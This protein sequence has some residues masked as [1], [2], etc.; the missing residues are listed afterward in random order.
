MGSDGIRFD[1]LHEAAMTH[2]N[3][4]CNDFEDCWRRGEP[5][6]IEDVMQEVEEALRPTLIRELLPIEIMYH[7]RSGISV[8][9]D[10][11][12]EQF[13]GFSETWFATIFQETD[14]RDAFEPD[15]IDPTK[16]AEFPSQLGDYTIV[17]QIGVGGMG[18]VYEAHHERMARAVAIKVLRSELAFQPQT[19]A[20]FLREIR[21]AASLSHPNIVT[22]YDSRE[23]NGM[24]YLVTELVDGTN[25]GSLV[26]QRGP[27]PHSEAIEYVVQAANGLQ[28]AH[29]HGVIHRDI[30]PQNLMLTMDQSISTPEPRPR[31]K[32]LD[33]G[34]AQL[35]C[36][37]DSELTSA[38]TIM[39]TP[40]YMAPEQ[41][42]RP[43]EVDHRADIYSLGC[44]LYYL[45]TA[46][47]AYAGD[48]VIETTMA[49]VNQPIPELVDV[50]P[51][52]AAIMKPVLEKMM[53]KDPAARFQSMTDVIA[54]LSQIEGVGQITVGTSSRPRKNLPALAGTRRRSLRPVLSLGVVVPLLCIGFA[55]WMFFR[56]HPIDVPQ[57]AALN[58]SVE[59]AATALG[60][61]W[62]LSFDGTTSFI[63]ADSP[64][65]TGEPVTIEAIVTVRDPHISVVAVWFDG[66][67]RAGLGVTLEGRWAIGR[68]RSEP[69]R[70]H[71]H[72]QSQYG[73]ASDPVQTYQRTHIAAVFGGNEMRLFV[74]GQEQTLQL[75][76]GYEPI[77]LDRIYIGNDAPAE[78]LPARP[79]PDRG[80]NGLVHA[81]RISNNVRYTSNFE[82]P[83]VLDAK[84]G[85]H[86]IVAFDIEEGEGDVTRDVLGRVEARIVDAQWVQP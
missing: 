53:A 41:A 59:P 36:P 30:K 56:Q 71:S 76:D 39:G 32:I 60:D 72:P 25:L 74:N 16:F 81:L 35:R 23:E 63:E 22:A 50:S 2:I 1:H 40:A 52:V 68:C 27:L 73:Q 12:R 45:L 84:P 43:N 67:W 57:F 58:A 66:K 70:D 77:E 24:A 28:Y 82:P 7:R 11:Y 4:L 33:F 47:P 44:T 75:I 34:L 79:H 78:L 83:T 6:A 42:M 29:D 85:D 65:F 14:D 31:V 5:K 49:H 13:P 55:S 18:T 21:A 37:D 80:F 64:G 10:Q 3:R 15:K 46:R 20:R 38:S 69:A 51:N 48:T 86:S 19:R 26:K 17:G 62:A 9:I 54:A 8:S 61:R